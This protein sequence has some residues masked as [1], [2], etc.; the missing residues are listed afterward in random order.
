MIYGPKTTLYFLESD[1][2]NNRKALFPLDTAL[3]GIHQA[4]YVNRN[5]NLYTDLGNLGTALRPVFYQTPAIGSQTGLNAYG[6]Y[7]YQTQTIRY[8]DTRSP[9]TN[10]DLMLGGRGQNL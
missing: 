7:G 6:L 10:M 1:V 3:E 5:D 9:Y 8:F 4:N 2:L